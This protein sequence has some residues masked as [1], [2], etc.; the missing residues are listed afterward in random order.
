MSRTRSLSPPTTSQRLRDLLA[1]YDVIE[2]DLAAS[3]FEPIAR[4]HRL[5][6]EDLATR[7][8]KHAFHRSRHILVH[9]V[10]KLDDDDGALPGRSDKPADHS[11]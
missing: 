9:A 3:D 4:V 11:A 10:R 1:A 6:I 7:E 2:R 5:D 8:P